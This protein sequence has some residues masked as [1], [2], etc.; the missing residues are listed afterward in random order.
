MVRC[1]KLADLGLTYSFSQINH[2]FL[3]HLNTI[4]VQALQVRSTAEMS[5][6]ITYSLTKRVPLKDEN[7]EVRS[8]VQRS[9]DDSSRLGCQID[10]V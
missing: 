2:L 7:T 1:Q 9:D 3:C 5:R 4:K 10:I 8:L 6:E